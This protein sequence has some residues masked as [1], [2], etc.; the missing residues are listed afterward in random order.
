MADPGAMGACE[1]W[2]WGNMWRPGLMSAAKPWG[3]FM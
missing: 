3:L 2:G 1:R